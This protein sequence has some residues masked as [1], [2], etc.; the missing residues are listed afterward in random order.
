[1]LLRRKGRRWYDEKLSGAVFFI[2]ILQVDWANTRK[3]KKDLLSSYERIKA[4]TTNQPTKN[5]N[6]KVS[7]CLSLFIFSHILFISAISTI[8]SHYSWAD[9][10]EQTFQFSSYFTDFLSLFL[11]L[12]RLSTCVD[13][14]T[15]FDDVVE[16]FSSLCRWQHWLSLSKVKIWNLCNNCNFS[17]FSL[18][19]FAFVNF[20]ST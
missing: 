13:D 2:S 12:S 16:I 9:D 4:T 6:Y 14:P 11:S 19:H 8:S 15:T 18:S 3:H 10:D 5:S 20:V 17:W 1:M 7:W